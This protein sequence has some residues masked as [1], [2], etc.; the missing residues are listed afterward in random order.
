MKLAD[1]ADDAL[2]PIA[3]V[4]VTVQVYVLPVVMAVTAI[5]AVV[6]ELA[7]RV[8][9]PLLDVHV[10]VYRVI[11]LPPVAGMLC[12]TVAVVPECVT[13]GAFGAVGTVTTM[14]AT[15]AA[16][17]GPAP[18]PLVATAVQVYVL[19]FVSVLTVTGDVLEC[20]CVVPPLLDVHVTV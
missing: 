14:N 18:M 2:V 6:V 16:D 12:V 15:D 1:G 5:A 17:A 3:L 19:P 20:D 4:A 13:V 9:P 7:D 8:V 10:A 11:V